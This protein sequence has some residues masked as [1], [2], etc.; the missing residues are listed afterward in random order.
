MTLSNHWLIQSTL[1][2]LLLGAGFVIPSLWFLSIVGVAWLIHQMIK[3]GALVTVG[4]VWVA[5]LVKYLLALGWFWSVY[6]IYWLETSVITEALI[7]GFYWVTAS[8][9]LSVGGLVFY[10]ILKNLKQFLSRKIVLGIAPFIWLL[11][12]LIGAL[13]FSIATIGPGGTV[14]TKFS[15]GFIGYHL[16]QHDL[17][18]QFAVVAGVY[19]LTLLLLGL[20]VIFIYGWQANYRK[21]VYGVFFVLLASSFIGLPQTTTFQKEDQISIVMVDTWYPNNGWASDE[22]LKEKRDQNRAALDVAL[23]QKADYI[24]FPEDSQVFDQTVPSSTL[25]AMLQF[26]YGRSS[27]VIIDSS[28]VPVEGGLAVQAMVFDPNSAGLEQTQ[29]QYLVPQGEYIPTLYAGLMRLFGFGETVD[30]LEMRMR[31][32]VGDITS[33]N[34]N[35]LLPPVLF[36][37]ESVAPNSVRSLLQQRSEPVPFV[38]HIVSHSWFNEPEILWQQL[39][40]MLRIQAIWNDTHIAVAGNHSLGYVVDPKGFIIEPDVIDSADYWQVGVVTI[41]K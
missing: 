14:T 20:S 26:V 25:R 31:Y 22:D 3:D 41:P 16:A 17:L 10:F 38:A 19:G 21:T 29:K 28:S 35:S 2:G 40:S 33:T 9:W 39:E 23:T 8:L 5:W 1:V 18:I 32:R 37:F 6:P 12:E 27:S 4:F 30:F 11:S 7:I 13:F 36:C 24:I 34:S 15:F